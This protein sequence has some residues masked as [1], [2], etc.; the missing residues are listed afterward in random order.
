MYLLESFAKKKKP[1]DYF[2]A[3]YILGERRRK[4]R[5]AMKP[6]WVKIAEKERVQKE[7]I[8]RKYSRGKPLLQKDAKFNDIKEKQHKKP[9]ETTCS[10]Q[11][12]METSVAQVPYILQKNF[13]AKLF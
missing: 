7:F 13:S 4:C 6:K 3:R 2:Q 12:M 1:S 10:A 8:Q 11:D 5:L 9:N